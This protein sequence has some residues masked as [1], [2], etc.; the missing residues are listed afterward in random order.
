MK[1]RVYKKDNQNSWPQINCPIV[2]YGML[3]GNH[4]ILEVCIWDREF[5]CFYNQEECF[6]YH[7]DEC[8]YSYISYVPSGY[9]TSY[10]VKCMN[11]CGDRCAYDDNGYCMA[12]KLRC[13]YA[14]TVPEYAIEEKRIWKEF[15]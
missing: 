15:E 3:N 11:D 12:E 4:L 14:K 1:W 5:E 13:K 7:F 8:Y 10:P 6:Y 2:V 9:K